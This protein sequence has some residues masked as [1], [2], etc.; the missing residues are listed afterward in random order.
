MYIWCGCFRFLF[1]FSM[2]CRNKQWN[3]T[4]DFS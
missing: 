1:E 4:S 3:A 2:L